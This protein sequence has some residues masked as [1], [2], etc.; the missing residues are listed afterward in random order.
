MPRRSYTLVLE[1]EGREI[2]YHWHHQPALP[3]CGGGVG[4]LLPG[5]AFYDWT[6]E[7]V[8]A[9]N[10]GTH[11]VEF[12]ESA[13]QISKPDRWSGSS[14][15]VLFRR[16]RFGQFCYRTG[17]STAGE[18]HCHTLMAFT[19]E[20]A[21]RVSARLSSDEIE[22]LREFASRIPE[23]LKNRSDDEFTIFSSGAGSTPIPDENL[24]AI[25]CHLNDEA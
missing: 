15:D 21:A 1:V 10:E 14:D 25:R 7:D 16:F 6:Y 17:A 18:R 13:L 8:L 5:D 22:E 24:H 4:V 11:T 3:N 19:P 23:S 12:D 2:F 20:N 9:L